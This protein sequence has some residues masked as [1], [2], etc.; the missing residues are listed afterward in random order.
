MVGAAG[1]RAGR[2]PGRLGLG[3]LGAEGGKGRRAGPGDDTATG[4]AEKKNTAGPRLGTSGVCPWYHPTSPRPA[5]GAAASPARRGRPARCG[6][7][8]TGADRLVRATAAAYWRR[9]RG[10]AVRGGAPR[11]SSPAFPVPLRSDRGSLPR[12]R[13]VLVLIVAS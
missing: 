7:P 11:S 2:G 1:S 6:G 10:P 9:A 5:S 4:R 3:A 12:S 13:R 8:L